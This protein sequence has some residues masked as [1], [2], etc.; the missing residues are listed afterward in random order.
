MSSPRYSQKTLLPLKSH[1]TSDIKSKGMGDVEV[2][3]KDGHFFEVIEVK[4]G[5]PITFET[6]KLA[7]DT[8]I[9][10]AKI[11]RYYLLSTA[12]PDTSDTEKVQ[13]LV[14]QIRQEHGCEVIVNGLMPSLKYYLRLLD[15][16]D[17]FVTAY[18][19]A[20]QHQFQL[21]TD[22]THAHLSVWRDLQSTL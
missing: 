20:L 3:S 11:E 5:K 22:V 12:H 1:T 18:A 2:T 17:D 10:R 13:T 7:Y 16:V 8:K 15:S 21:G 19:N 6:V 14:R 9:R 4:H